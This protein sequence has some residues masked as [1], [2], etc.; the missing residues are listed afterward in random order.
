[1]IEKVEPRRAQQAADMGLELAK[2]L[3]AVQVAS[4]LHRDI[5]A[6]NMMR[7]IGLW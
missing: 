3:S 4:L 6:G 2:A 1:L 5:K 7:E